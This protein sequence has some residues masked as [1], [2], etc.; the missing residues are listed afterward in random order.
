MMSHTKSRVI[1]PLTIDA[2]RNNHFA[3]A[4]YAFLSEKG[5]DVP[6]IFGN[7]SAIAGVT[8]KDE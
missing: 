7:S 8:R 2:I 6:N 4:V 1:S 3:A 5:R